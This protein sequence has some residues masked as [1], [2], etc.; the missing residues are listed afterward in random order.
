MVEQLVIQ[1]LAEGIPRGLVGLEM[2]AWL[3]VFAKAVPLSMARAEALD[4]RDVA[5]LARFV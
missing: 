5:T 3:Q 2:V 4:G 1:A